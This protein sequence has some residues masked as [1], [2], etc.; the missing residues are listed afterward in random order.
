MGFRI[1]EDDEVSGIDLVLH[2]ETAYDL[3]ST[4][5][6]RPHFGGPGTGSALA[7]ILSPDPDKKDV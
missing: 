7:H 3:H 4:P 5:G 2:A 6:A 1:H